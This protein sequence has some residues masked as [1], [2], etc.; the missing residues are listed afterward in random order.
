MKVLL[1]IKP[2]FVNAIRS[3]NKS[4]EYR[5]CIFKREIKTII[6]YETK[7][8][9]RIVGE[10]DIEY[11]LHDSPKIIWKKTQHSAGVDEEFYNAYFNNKELAFAIKIK[12]FKE[13]DTPLLLSEF[14][15]KIKVA[16]QSFLY[17]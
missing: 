11:I 8:V 10:F 1:S 15:P 17:L 6:V 12:K 9:G 16:P 7:P 3:G 14:D 4:F 2:E 5:K 13:Y